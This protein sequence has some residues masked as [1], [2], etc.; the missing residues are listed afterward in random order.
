MPPADAL[1]TF[2]QG[3]VVVGIVLGVIV[4]LVG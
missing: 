1:V 3:C 2:F 4:S